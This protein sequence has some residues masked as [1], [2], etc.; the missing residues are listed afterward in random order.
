MANWRVLKTAVAN[1]I[2]TNGNQAI[3]G[4]LLQNALNNII[5]NVGENSTFAGIATVDTNPG[6]P[7]GP[8]FYLATTAGTYPNFNSI[9]VL[10]GEAVIFEWNNGTWTKKVSGFA[11]Q[12]NL[13]QLGQEV[14][15]S[16]TSDDVFE[17]KSITNSTAGVIR[18][19]WF[20]SYLPKNTV[21]RI[22]FE[23]EGAVD[24]IS[25]YNTSEKNV[26]SYDKFFE[27]KRDIKA[28]PFEYS[29]VTKRD[30][31]LMYNCTAKAGTVIKASLFIKKT[32]EI[33]RE[34]NEKIDSL[35]KDVNGLQVNQKLMS[36]GETRVVQSQLGQ[37]SVSSWA[38]VAHGIAIRD[39]DT[40]YI[41]KEN[42]TP[43][44]NQIV[45]GLYEGKGLSTTECFDK[46]IVSGV[47]STEEYNNTP[48]GGAVKFRLPNKIDFLY[49]KYYTFAIDL[50]TQVESNNI[51]LGACDARNSFNFIQASYFRT[52]TGQSWNVV[53]TSDRNRI[54]YG[55]LWGVYLGEGQSIDSEKDM[56][57]KLHMNVLTATSK[58][59]ESVKIENEN[60]KKEI[61]PSQPAYMA[62]YEYTASKNE[63]ESDNL[64]DYQ[65]EFKF[66]DF[67]FQKGHYYKL[68]FTSDDITKVK[69]FSVYNDVYKND[70]IEGYISL[71]NPESVKYPTEDV[72][73]YY[74]AKYDGYLMYNMKVS[75]GHNLNVTVF[76]MKQNVDIKRIEEATIKG[77]NETKEDMDAAKNIVF[78]YGTQKMYANKT[79]IIRLSQVKSVSSY[80]K[81]FSLYG[82]Y[83]QGTLDGGYDTIKEYRDAS[84]LEGQ[85]IIEYTPKKDCYLMCN[86]YAT[87]NKKITVI[88]YDEVKEDSFD[89]LN[90][91]IKQKQD[92]LSI[93]NQAKTLVANSIGKFPCIK[94]KL[95]DVY[96]TLSGDS[97]F[98]FQNVYNIDKLGV[99]AVP[100][101]CDRTANAN[102]LWNA[103]KWGNAIYRRFDYGKASLLSGY[104]NSFVDDSKAVFAETGT[105]KTEYIGAEMRNTAGNDGSKVQ[106]T[107]KVD[108]GS[109]PY[110]FDNSEDSRWQRNIPKRFSNSANASIQFVIPAGY[111]KFDFLFH[112]HISGDIVTITTNR[113]SG[114]V[115]VNNKPNDWGNAIEANNAKRDLSM[116]N[117]TDGTGRSGG[118][119]SFGIPNQ[120]LYF[121]ISDTSRDTVVTIT[122]TSDTTKYLIYWGIT[123]WGTTTLPYALHINNMAVGGYGQDNIYNL[124][125]SM[126]QY[127]HSDA[128]ILEMCYNSLASK[129]IILPGIETQMGNLKEFFESIDIKLDK[130]GVW[131]PHCGVSVYN[132]APE[133]IQIN[134]QGSERIALELGYNVIAN[135]KKLCDDI[136]Q[137]YYENKT[138]SQFMQLMGGDGVHL[139]QNGHDIYQAAWES[140]R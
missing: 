126:F 60:L 111:G 3:T 75:F 120:R 99:S 5:T 67:Y 30:G 94:G 68:L 117:Y 50:G 102:K 114:I 24:Q 35:G 100:P 88:L 134:N 26:N 103:L 12:E 27:G 80:L 6:V 59:I 32:I 83:K 20:D 28:F 43:L 119:D 16:M 84:V 110:Q 72:E 29:F 137:V 107:T 1:I 63:I 92:T 74:K 121:Q 19:A 85:T 66:T 106:I 39:V 10:D 129:T 98:A 36:F 140:L 139:G 123:Y 82:L 115:K 34:L 9:K 64:S 57:S 116:A 135:V 79:Y 58:A 17:Q 18:F 69:Q 62:S 118:N 77:G 38:S 108:F 15:K 90:N 133:V 96:L 47:I 52:P 86:T 70:Y 127:I 4:Q 130:I 105:F 49:E 21:C 122:K 125:K 132:E 65:L 33:E 48:V 14:F 56:Q 53:S 91:K 138:G 93:K 89:N 76:E 37:V 45:V 95:S 51:R 40:L 7:D 131:L 113:N 41:I 101:T 23:A 42:E 44:Q 46:A 136:N 31:Y 81:T 73:V 71:L 55:L 112:S 22:I 25:F 87:T 8:V 128:V 78:Y 97:T 124:R 61:T 11:T 54:N 109:F 2:N 13:S 104:D